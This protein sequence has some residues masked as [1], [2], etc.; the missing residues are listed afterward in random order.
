MAVTKTSNCGEYFRPEKWKEW[1]ESPT[2]PLMEVL[3]REDIDE[4]V[5]VILCRED[6]VGKVPAPPSS[7][8]MVRK[9][10]EA[11]EE[12]R[13][14]IWGRKMILHKKTNLNRESQIAPVSF[15]F[16]QRD[17]E[18]SHM[19]GVIQPWGQE[20]CGQ[21][22][23]WRLD[24]QERGTEE[25][26]EEG[27]DTW[28]LQ[29]REVLTE[30]RAAAAISSLSTRSRSASG[31]AEALEPGPCGGV[32]VRPRPLWRRFKA[33]G[34][35]G[36]CANLVCAREKHLLGE[37]KMTDLSQMTFESSSA[38]Q[39]LKREEQRGDKEGLVSEKLGAGWSGLMLPCPLDSKQVGAL[40]SPP[41]GL[42]WQG[43]SI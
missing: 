33:W 10:Q 40:A 21:T 28:Q 18:N 9:Q 22:E 5:Q 14:P 30:A 7:D 19:V 35:L 42:P 34:R 4:A 1:P 31:G 36:E 29:E 26:E 38:S 13:T 25:Q 43:G 41:S 3:A 2:V 32:D 27:C 15:H 11:I 24:R 6:F 8:T 39:K 16:M 17:P 37:E 12:K 23:G 20:E